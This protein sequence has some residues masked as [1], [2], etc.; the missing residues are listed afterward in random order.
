MSVERRKRLL[1][2]VV[3]LFLMHVP[4]RLYRHG[5]AGFAPGVRAC[6]QWMLLSARHA[7]FDRERLKFRIVRLRQAMRISDRA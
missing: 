5:G 2:P 6:V 1:I 4:F 3:R 7:L